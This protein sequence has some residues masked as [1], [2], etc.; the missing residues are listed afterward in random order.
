MLLITRSS[1]CVFRRSGRLPHRP[2]L[3]RHPR[4]RDRRRRHGHQRLPRQAHRLRP[5]RHPRRPRRHRPGPR[6]LHAS[7]PSS[8]S[9]P[10]PYRPTPPSCSPRSSSAAWAPSADPL[11]GAA[12]LYL[13]PA[14]LQFLGDYQLLAFGLAL[15]LLMRFRPEGLIANRRQPA[16]IPRD[17][18]ARRTD[19]PPDG[20]QQGRGLTTMTTTHHQRAAPHQRP[21]DRPR[22]H[23]ASPCASAA[24]P[25]YATSTSPSTAA[26]SSASSAPTARARPPSSTASPASTSPPRAR[27]R[28]K[29]KVLP[30]K[31]HL[32]TA[33]RH[34]PHL[35]EHPALRQHDGPGERP[36]R[37]PHPHQGRPLVGPPARP[38][39]Q[40]GRS[41]VPRNAPWNSWSSSAS[42]HKADHLARNLP[43]GEQRK[44]EIARALA[45]DPG[46]LLLDEPTAGMN[47]Q[48]T[49]A[50][51]ELVFAI[52]DKGIAV[53]VIEHDMRFIFN[54]CDRVA[55][56]RP[57]RE[58][59]RRHRRR[60][61]GRRA[62]H[63][64]LPRRHP[65]KAPPATEKPPKSKR[66]KHA[67]RT[68]R[69]TSTEGERPSDR[70][71][72]GRGPP[73]RLRQDRSRQGHLLQRRRRR[74]RHPHRHQRRRQDHHPAHPLR[75]AQAPRRPDHAS[76]AS[77]STRSPPT[78]SSP[79]ASPT[80]PR[81][82]T[83]S[84]A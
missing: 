1:S 28:Y 49:R 75:A 14:K 78:R 81:A 83:S 2:R 30:P 7:P 40:E 48:E 6:H 13:I 70:T 46:L 61:P 67:E 53:L 45:S 77:R 4:G 69:D 32:V 27:S 19:R 39:L 80:P 44:L 11:L 33:G 57:G 26:R 82:G 5:R 34:R 63:R 65:S 60:R 17:R 24:S 10:T 35:P 47:P 52:R 25:P 55:V 50:T 58:A 72:R 9:S 42:P 16:R 84:P 56:P 43:Y 51:E 36:R 71:A 37:P 73:G 74:G 41:R 8:T 54:L 22:R 29:G 64:R 62:R 76:T 3:G 18:P 12:L 15:V 31:S 20:P 23:A 66:P 79:W 59:R 21:A 38:R 68:Q